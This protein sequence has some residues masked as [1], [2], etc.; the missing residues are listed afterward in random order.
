MRRYFRRLAVVLVAPAA[1]FTTVALT[2]GSASAGTDPGVPSQSMIAGHGHGHGLQPEF[3]TFTQVN[4]NPAVV[5]ASGPVHGTFG[6]DQVSG[7]SD[8][9]TSDQGNVNVLHTDVSN[10][11]PQTDLRSC[12]A[13]AVAFGHWLFDGG[14]AK[15]KNAFGFGRFKFTLFAVFRKH[16]GRCRI[17]EK[18]QPK[19]VIVKVTAW[20]KATAGHHHGRR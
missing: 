19:F 4:D 3:F 18:T 7:T 2:A 10:V 6:D 14:T 12:T 13:S 17:T 1:V 20:G 11:Q 16:H 15:Y 9:F 5:Q 8:V